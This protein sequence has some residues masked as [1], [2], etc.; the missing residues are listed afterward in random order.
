MKHTLLLLIA[1]LA[2]YC[3]YSQ[4]SHA[5]TPQQQVNWYHL[6]SMTASEKNVLALLDGSRFYSRDDA[7]DKR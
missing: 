4:D 3:C 5:E 2:L 7:A 6:L 1:S